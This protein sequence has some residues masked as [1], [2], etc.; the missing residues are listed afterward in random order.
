MDLV[1]SPDFIHHV[2]H[3][4]YNVLKVIHAGV[5]LGFGTVTTVVI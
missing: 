3:F 5:G 4:Q 2:Y 1:S